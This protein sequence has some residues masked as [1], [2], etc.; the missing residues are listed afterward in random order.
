MSS[1]II[2]D[3]DLQVDDLILPADMQ[4]QRIYLFA[5]TS[6]CLIVQRLCA[7]LKAQ[8]NVD[9]CIV[10]SA[11]RINDEVTQMQAQIHQWSCTW[12]DTKLLGRPLKSWLLLPDHG[13]SSWW[14]GLI[15]EKNS[16]QDD[17]F[18]KIA[19]LNAI[20]HYMATSQHAAC[21]LALGDKL[22]RR[23]VQQCLK[24]TD[25]PITVLRSRGKK[26]TFSRKQQLLHWISQGG[27]TGALL[28]ALVHLGLWWRQG[29]LARR[30]LAPLS[31][32]LRGNHPLLFISY[33][34]NIDEAA[35]QQGILYNRYADALQSKCVEL[36]IPLT[37]LMMPVYY[38]GH[39]YAS[40]VNLAKRFS[41]SGEKIFLLQEFF[42]FAVFCKSIYYWL[43]QLII[44]MILRPLISFK[45]ISDPLAVAG[46]APLMQYLWWHSLIGTSGIRGILFYLT[47]KEI[48]K[49]MSGVEKCLYFCEM[50]AWEKACIAAKNYCAPDAVCL[51]FQ[52]TVVMRNYFNYFYVAQE[53]QRTGQATDMPL[54]DKLIANGELM[55]ALL[56]E[57]AYPNL[58]QAEAIRQL[59][60]T[61]RKRTELNS[62]ST[63]RDSVICLIV[64]S[65]DKKETK[66]LL[67]LFMTAFPTAPA[68]EVWVKGSPVNPVAPILNE[69]GLNTSDCYLKICDNNIAQLLE[70]ASIAF[71]ANT[72]VAIEAVG[73]GCEVMIPVLADTMLMNPIIN[74]SATYSLITT[75][76]ELR[77]RLNAHYAGDVRVPDR[78][79]DSF[80]H[81]YWNLDAQLPLWTQLLTA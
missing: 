76:Q 6:N 4:Q 58:C 21:Y 62:V 34:P 53:T 42:T 25:V 14:F 12:G 31:S 55:Y 40:A 1:C 16:V 54:P 41:D 79:L 69:L 26:P 10:A 71:V 63:C 19:Q 70:V 59:Y 2:F 24:E 51:A 7:A 38:N 32:R 73:F 8:A 45:S 67:T 77:E 17:V 72:T 39:D 52:H 35:A 13:V 48:F 49:K 57:S 20:K 81:H 50:Q 33:F 61:K 43:R 60:L 75:P 66:A 11:Q 5:L 44:S 23:S 9:V 78:N 74:T 15:S 29:R 37:W 56:K 3:D 68:F 28:S 80:I 47:Y 65:C 46:S 64:G 27:V 36:D 22:L 30:S 18:F